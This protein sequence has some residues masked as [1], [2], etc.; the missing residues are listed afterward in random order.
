MSESPKEPT[1]PGGEAPALTRRTPPKGTGA[2]LT[3]ER[4]RQIE[5]RALHIL[6]H[7]LRER[8]IRGLDDLLP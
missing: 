2:T 6:R 5:Q 8:G 4:I 7:K 3:R 1:S